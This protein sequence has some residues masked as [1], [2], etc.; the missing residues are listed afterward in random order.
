MNCFEIKNAPK[1]YCLADKNDV[2]LVGYAAAEVF[3]DAKYPIPVLDTDH[4]TLLKLKYETFKLMAENAIKKGFVIYED[5]FIANILVV[6]YIDSCHTPY[7]EL[8]ELIRKA[9][10]NEAADNYIKTIE[11]I[12]ELE[13]TIKISEDAMY[14]EIFAV[15][16]AI[17][18]KGY[19]SRLMKEVIKLCDENKRDLFLYT[20]NKKNEAIYNHF[21][22]ETILADDSKET[23]YTVFML[24]KAK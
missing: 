4:D 3:A 15:Q 2:N 21:G 5:N 13:K 12:I 6:P 11:R 1:G 7:K 16:T 20:N 24:H 19:G 22:F 8:A 17:Q 14:V 9:G 23:G 18:G 10:Y